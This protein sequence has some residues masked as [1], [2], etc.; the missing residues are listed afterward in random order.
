[1]LTIRINNLRKS[2]TI[3]KKK[4]WIELA[5]NINIKMRVY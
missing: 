5:K 2:F 1:M 4:N 3:A